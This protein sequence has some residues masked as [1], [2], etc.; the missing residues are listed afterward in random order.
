MRFR[1]V[2]EY[3]GE[4]KDIERM[5]DELLDYVNNHPEKIGVQGN[6]ELLKYIRDELKK[7]RDK[8]RGII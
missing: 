3:D 8:L 5:L 4:I 2:D 6:Y 7:E 1:T